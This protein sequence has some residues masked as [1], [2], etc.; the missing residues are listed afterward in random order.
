M[1]EVLEK[2]VAAP[3]MQENRNLV[4]LY[5]NFIA[6]VQDKLNPLKLAHILVAA[7]RQL[8]GM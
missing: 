7:S 8:S 2:V 4:N 6:P 5:R 1:T 3:F